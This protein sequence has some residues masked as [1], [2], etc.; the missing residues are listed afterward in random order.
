MRIIARVHRI[1][2]ALPKE[3]ALCASS[4][5]ESGT[6]GGPLAVEIARTMAPANSSDQS[7][8][9]GMLASRKRKVVSASHDS[10]DQHRCSIAAKA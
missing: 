8:T 6:A 1:S 10:P 4:A 3:R 7:S 2:S 5:R 9:T